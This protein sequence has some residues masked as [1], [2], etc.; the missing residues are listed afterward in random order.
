[1][2]QGWP[3]NPSLECTPSCICFHK[4]PCWWCH[5][6]CLT[7]LPD[8]DGF[9]FRALRLDHS[10]WFFSPCSY[11]FFL[12][13][14]F[15][16]PIGTVI[17]FILNGSWWCCYSVIVF[18]SKALPEQ[19]QLFLLKSSTWWTLPISQL[20]GLKGSQVSPSTPK[21]EWPLVQFSPPVWDD[22]GCQ[23]IKSNYFF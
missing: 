9:P 3:L 6:C 23:W 12:C 18:F 1:M 20:F 11:G 13:P 8:I 22:R 16:I 19:L 21:A 4:C 7:C 17:R 15:T 5:L 10:H 14:V 2:S